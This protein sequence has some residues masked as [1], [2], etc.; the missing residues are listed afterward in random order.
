[1]CTKS[2]C[3][4][5]ERPDCSHGG[6]RAGQPRDRAGAHPEGSKREFG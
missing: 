1:M 5:I 3:S 2:L 6:V 4:A